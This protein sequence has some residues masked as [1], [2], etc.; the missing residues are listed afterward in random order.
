MGKLKTAFKFG[1]RQK[2]E[3]IP[4]P[5]PVPL[6]RGYSVIERSALYEPFVHA[7]IAQDPSTGEYACM[8]CTSS[9]QYPELINRIYYI[10]RNICFTES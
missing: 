8:H 5:P 2:E 7:V 9:N 10:S 4:P 1:K 6:S 3:I